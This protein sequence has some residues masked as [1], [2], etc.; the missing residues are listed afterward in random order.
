MR[1]FIAL[2]L[3]LWPTGR[4]CGPRAPSEDA[5]FALTHVTTGGERLY[6]LNAAASRAGLVRGQALADAKALEPVLKTVAADPEGDRRALTG[7]ARWC[8]RFSPWTAPDPGDPGL[9]GVLL[10]V[11]G[12]ARLF[13]GEDRLIAELLEAVRGLGHEAYAAAAPTIGLAWGLARHRAPDHAQGWVSAETP[14]PALSPLPV[15]AL[16]IGGVADSLRRFGLKRVGD[17]TAIPRP[18]LARRFGAEAVRRLDQA[19]GHEQESL[20]PLQ[21]AIRYR[22]RLRFPEALLLMESLKQAVRESAATLCEKLEADG[23]GLRRAL[24]S[25]YRVDGQTQG[26]V[27]G[28]AAPARDPAHIARLFHEKLDRARLDIGFGVDLVELSA[29]R[30]EALGAAQDDLGG[31]RAAQAEDMARLTDRLV[32]RLGPEGVKQVAWRESHQIERAGSWRAGTGGGPLAVTEAPALPARER[33]LLILT[34]P[35]PADAVAEIP[36]GPPRSFIWR[37]TRHLVA[38]AEGPER[39]AP[40]WWRDRVSPRTRDY[41]RVETTEGRRFWLYREGLFGRETRTPRW[42]VCGAS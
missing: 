32:A 24:L 26:L 8:G 23:R 19:R 11:T 29:L 22:A 21:P 13:N 37:R 33:P 9:D 5:P 15:E 40:D 6:A 10:D 12:C 31:R 20:S 36:D 38:G 39:L 4:L 30:T 41:F 28:A 18:Q 42:F 34:R 7:L 25:L 27:I 3:P 16:R 2:S 35:E 1:R 14:E 17:L